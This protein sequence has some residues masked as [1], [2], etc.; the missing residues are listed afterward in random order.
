MTESIS[1]EEVCPQHSGVVEAITSMKDELH[2]Q[3]TVLEK[4]AN[5]P[6]LW[7]TGAMSALA[8]MLGWAMAWII[9]LHGI[10]QN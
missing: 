9:H 4:V 10:A 3:N 6:P 2:R 8:F 1:S 7:A 5:R